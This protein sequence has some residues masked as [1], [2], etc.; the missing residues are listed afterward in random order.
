MRAGR[1]LELIENET[2]RHKAFEPVMLLGRDKYNA[3]DIRVRV[4]GGGHVAQAY[5]IRQSLAKAIVSYYQKCAHPP[6]LS[7]LL[8]CLSRQ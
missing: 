6:L 8:R 7:R 4:K 2:L 1:P 3:L 5:A